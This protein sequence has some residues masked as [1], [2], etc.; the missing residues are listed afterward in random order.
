MARTAGGRG[1]D[2]KGQNS[3]L[4]PT[5]INMTQDSDIDSMTALLPLEN[6]AYTA[7]PAHGRSFACHSDVFPL[8]I[9]TYSEPTAQ[10]TW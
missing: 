10:L 6:L 5:L 9:K 2:T 4:S 8:S 1:Q 3:F 7:L